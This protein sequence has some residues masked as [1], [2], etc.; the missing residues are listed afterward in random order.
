MAGSTVRTCAATGRHHGRERVTEDT[1]HLVAIR[2]QKLR[3]GGL[4]TRYTFQ[5]LFPET[6]FPQPSPTPSGQFSPQLLG[7]LPLMKGPT[8]VPATSWGPGLQHMSL[9]G[10]SSYPTHVCP[11]LVSVFPTQKTLQCPLPPWEGEQVHF[12]GDKGLSCSLGGSHKP[13]C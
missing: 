9:L 10:D 3:Q 12:G 6:Y 4:G 2:K 13:A 1:S 5:G 7:G 11:H 8:R